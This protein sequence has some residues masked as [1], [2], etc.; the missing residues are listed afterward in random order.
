LLAC[1]SPW[2]VR[3][4]GTKTAGTAAANS[5]VVPVVRRLSTKLLLLTV[6]FVLISE[7]LIFPPSV[8]NFRLQWLQQRLATAAA[9][10]VVLL[11]ADLTKIPQ[12]VQDDVLRA[13]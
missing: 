2:S 3:K 5:G 8:A 11:Q 6:S 9:V 7:L 12:G 4:R 13:T 10:S 1:D